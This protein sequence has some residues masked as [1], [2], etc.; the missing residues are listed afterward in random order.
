MTGT[1]QRLEIDRAR[2]GMRVMPDVQLLR[3]QLDEWLLGDVGAQWRSPVLKMGADSELDLGRQ[4]RWTVRVFNGHEPRKVRGVDMD[5][6]P[7][8]S[9]VLL[10]K[11]NV[12]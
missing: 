4:G 9:L 2:A 1:L 8:V 12:N 6:E 10:R 7:S 5:D 11:A 3:V